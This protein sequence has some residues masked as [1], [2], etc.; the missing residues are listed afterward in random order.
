MYNRQSFSFNTLDL[1]FHCLPASMRNP[2]FFL[3]ILCTWWIFVLSG[4][5]AFHVFDYDVSKFGFLW[6]Y[7]IWSLLTSWT[8]RLMFSLKIWETLVILFP[9]NL[10]ALFTPFFP[11]MTLIVHVFAWWCSIVSRILLIIVKRLSHRILSN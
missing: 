11:S 2:L 8:C 3:R 10:S 6:V 9:N 1:S 4:V 7:C 5:S